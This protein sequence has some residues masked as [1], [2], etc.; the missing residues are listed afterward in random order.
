MTHPLQS[1]LFKT[2]FYRRIQ[3][4]TSITPNASRIGAYTRRANR[5]P[6]IRFLYE[7]R[8]SEPETGPHLLD[9]LF[10]KGL[11]FYFNNTT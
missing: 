11:I 5:L 3:T 1:L 8:G 9:Q 6:P 10:A 2:N 4:V 7:K